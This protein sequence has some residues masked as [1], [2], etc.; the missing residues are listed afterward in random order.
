MEDYRLEQ[1]GAEVQEILNTSTP[2]ADLTAETE[3]AQEAESVLGGRIDDEE[4]RAKAAEEANAGAI[5]D[6]ELRAKAAE[7]I[8]AN[9]I[10]AINE[11]IPSAASS[12]NKL[13]DVDFVNDSISTATATYRGSFNLVSDLHLAIDATH[14]QIETLLGTVISVAD[15]ND[16]CYVQIPTSAETPTQI[17]SVELYKFTDEGWKFGYVL[18]NSGF[19]AAQWAAL[20][21]AIT[22][23]LV[24]KLN[25]LPTNEE[26]AALLG[27]KQ[28]VLTFDD[29]PVEGSNNPVKSG[30]VH[31]AIDDEKTARVN[32]VNTLQGEIDGIEGKIPTGASA[33]NKLVDTATMNSSISTATATYRGDFNLVS[34]LHLAVDATHAQIATMLASEIATADNNDYCY[35]QIPTSAETPTQIAKVERYKYNGSAWGYEYDLNNSGFTASQWAALNSAITSGLVAKLSALPTNQELTAALA[36]KQDV[37]TFDQTPTEN[38]TNP[39]TSGGVYAADKDLSDAIEAIL[40]LIPSAAT[41]LNKLVDLAQMNSSISTATATYRGSYNLVSDLSLTIDATEQQIATA[42]A[43]TISTADN[44]DYA[45]VQIPTSSEAP[46]QIARTDRYKYNGSVWA[47]EYTLNTSGFTSAQWAAINSGITTV[48]VAKLSALPTNS[49]LTSALG[50]LNDGITGINLK[51]P[52]TASQSNKLIDAAGL[53][54]TLA[55]ALGAIDA[56]FNVQSTDGHVTLHITQVDGEITSVQVQSSDIASDAALTLVTNRVTTAEGNITNLQG[57]MSTAEGNISTNANDIATLQQL[58]NSLQQSLPVPV[59]SLPGSGQQQG[60]IYRLAGMTSY[61]D[62]M[63]NGS[64][65]VLLA[66]YNNAVDSAPTANSQNLVTSGGVFSSENLNFNYLTRF[67]SASLSLTYNAGGTLTYVLTRGTVQGYIYHQTGYFG[68]TASKTDTIQLVN[69]VNFVYFDSVDSSIKV[70]NNGKLIDKRYC[71]VI[72]IFYCYNYVPVYSCWTS[73][74]VTKS[75]IPS[76]SKGFANNNQINNRFNTIDTALNKLQTISRAVYVFSGSGVYIENNDDGTFTVVNGGSYLWTD[77]GISYQLTSGQTTLSITTGSSNYIYY[78]PNNNAFE[79]T[80][81][82]ANLPVDSVIIDIFYAWTNSSF[83]AFW[84]SRCVSHVSFPSEF[85]NSYSS[86]VRYNDIYNLIHHRLTRLIGCSISLTNNHDGTATCNI[87]RGGVQG[88]IYYEDGYYSIGSN[89][90]ENTF[91]LSENG[92]NFVY[93]DA[94]QQQV[95]LTNNA[96][97]LNNDCVILETF[98]SY[99]RTPVYSCWTSPDVVK[100]GIPSDSKGYVS[101][102]RINSIDSR[103]TALENSPLSRAFPYSVKIFRRIGCIGDSYTKGY[104]YPSGGSATQ[105]ENYAWPHYMEAITKNIY[106]N[107]GVSGSTAKGWMSGAAKLD[108]VQANGNKCQAYIIGLMINDRNQ[109]EWN[110]YYTPVGVIGDIGTDNDTYYAWYYK[111]VQAVITVNSSAPIFC[112]TCPKYASNDAYNQAVRDIVEYCQNNNQKVYLNDLASNT[113]SAMFS[114]SVFVADEVNG[115]YTAIGYEFMAECLKVV[116]SDT[117]NANVSDFQDVHLIPFDNPS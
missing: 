8:N 96:S 67:V 53:N 86:Y 44:N 50:L 29:V 71:I 105:D 43:A 89:F 63:W 54:E 2:Q 99:N 37:L 17:A 114:N 106:S 117:I 48:L 112:N 6:E 47:F 111:L 24:A 20:N 7:E 83:V 108:Q 26:L 75:G 55:L 85:T 14:A 101:N 36:A 38:S 4:L 92:V 39:V 45:F 33:D 90:I 61:S 95:L 49:E 11:K 27:A 113:Y 94:K 9:A 62:Y 91:Q 109:D 70:T 30:G 74:D 84:T 87:V 46:T 107:F 66:T 76:D 69:G 16:Y 19:T 81:S 88:Y 21:S 18:N 52:A 116:I 103:V 77:K 93:F 56:T 60:V 1:T 72:E 115:H 57:R 58:Y 78:N 100:S 102:D 104:I 32:N 98:Y 34:D 22:S 25:A 31:S 28:D 97:N 40:L 41:Q 51:I 3:R 68:I 65:W 5:H 59:T 64:D 12:E 82:F 35:V 15:K 79:I 10:A 23:G 13:A 73:P 42:L 80:N 110:P